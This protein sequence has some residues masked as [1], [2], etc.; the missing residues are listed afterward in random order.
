MRVTIDVDN[1]HNLNALCSYLKAK[2]YLGKIE[3][4]ESK[5]GYGFHLIQR[6]LNIKPEAT[7][8][9]RSIIGDDKV[10]L[11]LDS[12]H[13][14]KPRQVLFNE[15]HKLDEKNILNLPF[16]VVK[17]WRKKKRFIRWLRKKSKK[18]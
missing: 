10:R 17:T 7:L 14:G 5:S 12:I 3:I 1:P 18:Q 4:K 2:Y 13:S 15:K 8:I 9:L 16:K 11:L 6:G